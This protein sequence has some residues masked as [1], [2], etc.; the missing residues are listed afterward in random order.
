RHH[1]TPGIVAVPL[2]VESDLEVT[3]L[4]TVITL[5]PGTLSLHLTDDRRTLDVHAM[6]IDDPAVLVR[7]IKE[8]FERRVREVFR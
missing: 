8:G 2:D 7:G 1:M 4:A 5:T 3:V 6:Y